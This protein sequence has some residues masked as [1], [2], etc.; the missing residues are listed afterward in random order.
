MARQWLEDE[1]LKGET[2]VF[3]DGD[4]IYRKSEAALRAIQALSGI[5][6]IARAGMWAPRGLRDGLYD[7][8]ARRRRRWFG[9][10]ENCPL[11]TSVSGPGDARL[12]S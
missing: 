12:L 11:P 9:G 8:I 2:V 6:K 5:W 1:D 4:G 7:F 3:L 10:G